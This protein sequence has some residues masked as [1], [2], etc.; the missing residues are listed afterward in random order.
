MTRPRCTGQQRGEHAQR[1][2]LARA[3]G[4]EQPDDLAGRHGQV[5]P[6][7]GGRVPEAVDQA[8]DL[9][10]RACVGCE[11]AGRRGSR[12]CAGHRAPAGWASRRRGARSSR[13]SCATSA[14]SAP[15]PA[16]ICSTCAGSRASS[17]SV[18]TARRARRAASARACAAAPR[19]SR[20]TRRSSGS[21]VAHDQPERDEPGDDRGDGVG[22][23]AQ[24]AGDLGDRAPRLPADQQ[25]D[26]A[27]GGGER[28]VADGGAADAAQRP[29]EGAQGGQQGVDER[30]GDGHEPEHIP[31]GRYSLSQT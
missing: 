13:S 30:V 31:L 8:G 25:D 15:T 27:L 20:P 12:R 10:G 28:V 3:V 16:R 26:L 18:S 4:A 29:A 17:A 6:V 2:G 9:D 1:G 24:L 23:E 14:A 21:V 11:G 5:Q 19:L 7:D 22:R